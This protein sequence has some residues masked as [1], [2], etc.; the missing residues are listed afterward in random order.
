MKIMNIF[1]NNKYYN[2]ENDTNN[3]DKTISNININQNERDE[4]KTKNVC[5]YK[6]FFFFKKIKKIKN[7]NSSQEISFN[8]ITFSLGGQS[9]RT[10]SK[11][12]FNLKIRGGKELFGRRQFKLRSDSSEPS[13]MRTKLMCD[14]H[15]KLGLPSISANYIKLYINDEFMGLYILTDA[16]KESWIEYVYGEKDTTNL[17]KCEYCDLLYD[18]KN[19]FENENKEASDNQEL[20]EFL[21]AMTKAKSSV[22]VESIFDLDQFYKEIAI[23]YLSSSWDHIKDRH[24]YYVYKNPQNNKWIYLIHDFDLDLCAYYYQLSECI[25]YDF[26]KLFTY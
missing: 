17:Y 13:Y 11:P 9:S 26:K 14:I 18:T 19:G 15:N 7:N 10:Y 3:N 8:K 21:K 25:N 2:T 5:H 22:D 1:F 16:Y 23:E 4:F 20:Y 24:N 12:G 6:F